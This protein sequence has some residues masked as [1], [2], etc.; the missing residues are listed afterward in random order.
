MFFLTLTSETETNI[1]ETV[2]KSMINYAK[3][4]FFVTPCKCRNIDIEDIAHTT[5]FCN[6]F[7]VAL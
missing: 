4:V 7:T 5:F 2:K 6:L 3:P 1:F